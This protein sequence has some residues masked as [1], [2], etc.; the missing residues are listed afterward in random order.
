MM[1]LVTCPLCRAADAETGPSMIPGGGARANRMA[2]RC[3]Q[4]RGFVIESS[5]LQAASIAP[6]IG[7]LL[8]ERA[9]SEYR[10]DGS[11]MLE[12]TE[13]LVRSYSR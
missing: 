4:C 7:K 5:L 6:E 9:R 13:A 2:V 1:Q 11:A 8:S 10:D 3:P 12:V